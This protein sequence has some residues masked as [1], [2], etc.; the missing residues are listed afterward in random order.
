MIIGDCDGV[1]VVLQ[2]AEDEV[3]EKAKAK[4]EKEAHIVEQLIT[5]ENY[6]RDLWFR[7]ADQ[8]ID[9]S[10]SINYSMWLSPSLS[11]KCLYGPVAVEDVLITVEL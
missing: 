11:Q 5:G 3:F 4:F 9:V 1:V 10:V 8:K 7:P 6:L 2:E